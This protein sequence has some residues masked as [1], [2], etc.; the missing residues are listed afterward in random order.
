MWKQLRAVSRP[1]SILEQKPFDLV[2]TDLRMSGMDG[3]QV[4]EKVKEMSPDTEVVV[5]TAYGTIEGAVAAIKGGAYDYLT[6]P[7][8]PEEL[9]LVARRALERKGLAQRV[10]VLE[11]AV[12][13]REP[14][15][16]HWK[17][18]SDEGR[19]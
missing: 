9:T 2:I 3:I 5:M 19:S 18:T 8:Q 1:S 15:R 13:D 7:F 17:L 4:L 11:D 12:K 10:R 14:C 6:K 16:H